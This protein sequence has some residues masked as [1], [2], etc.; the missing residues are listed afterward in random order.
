MPIPELPP[1]AAYA[2]LDRFRLIDVREEHE[3]LGPLGFVGG[4]ELVPLATVATHAAKLD[5]SRPLLVI[6]RSGKRS[7]V[8]CETLRELGV[9]GAT[10]LAGG[11]IAWNR[12][13]L[14]VM[15]TE[16]KTIESLLASVVSWHAQGTAATEEEARQRMEASL[17]E[18]GASLDGPTAAALD[19]SLD[20]VA[21]H[22]RE[23]GA[24]PDLEMTL[25]AYRADLAVL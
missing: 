3:F 1:E 6:C 22:L 25:D 21:T 7:G 5:G 10:N 13:R 18:A 15:R 16:F 12:A 4:A 23:T 19:H 11:M 9:S 24:P 17:L 14:P 20:R 8:A 2:D